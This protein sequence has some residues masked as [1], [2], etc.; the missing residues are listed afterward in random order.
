MSWQDFKEHREEWV[1]REAKQNITLGREEF[2]GMGAFI[3]NFTG[4]GALIGFQYL[5]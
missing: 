5:D 4:I 3:Q 2:T 1:M